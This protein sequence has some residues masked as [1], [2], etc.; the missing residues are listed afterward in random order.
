MSDV[1]EW[2]D[3]D[4]APIEHPPV[5]HADE[6]ANPEPGPQLVYPTLDSSLDCWPQAGAARSMAGT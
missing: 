4:T 6:P 5:D 3:D 2:P 1:D